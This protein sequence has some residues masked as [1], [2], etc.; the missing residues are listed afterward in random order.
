MEL[1]MTISVRLVQVEVCLVEVAEEQHFLVLV[2]VLLQIWAILAN[3]KIIKK[4]IQIVEDREEM[5]VIRVGI[6]VKDSSLLHHLIY[7]NDSFAI[8]NNS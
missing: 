4:I 1:M 3:A 7:D 6:I 5:E 2:V 8:V